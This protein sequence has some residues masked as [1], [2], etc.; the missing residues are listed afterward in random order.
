MRLHFR[1]YGQGPP[2][3]ILHGLFGSLDNWSAISS[4]LAPDFHV[5][6]VDQRNHGGSLHSDEM[7]YRLMADDLREFMEDRAIDKAHV[8]GHSMGGKT[9]MQFALQYG[10]KVDRLVVVDVAPRAYEPEHEY[11][12]AA[13][14][15]LDLPKYRTRPEIEQALAPQIN[16]LAVRRFLLKNLVRSPDDMFEWRFNLSGLHRNYSALAG[17]LD[18]EGEF[19]GPSLFLRG[20]KSDYVADSDWPAIQKQFPRAESVTV[21]GAGHWVHVESMEFF[22]VTV[23]KFLGEKN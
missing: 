13:L 6:A 20:E 15:G 23:K 22:L 16:D 5:Y 3:I 21:P 4:R 9:A 11:I 7:N 8:L 18:R 17:G 14:F 12:F 19:D 1:E 10:R 2:L